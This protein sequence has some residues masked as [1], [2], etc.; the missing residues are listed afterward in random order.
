MGGSGGVSLDGVSP[1]DRYGVTPEWSSGYWPI[2]AGRR[3]DCAD[4][5]ASTCILPIPDDCSG[6][7]DQP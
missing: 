4:T 2:G 6:L 7:G 5:G 3:C 1:F